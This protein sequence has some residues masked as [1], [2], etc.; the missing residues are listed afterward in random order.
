[1]KCVRVICIVLEGFGETGS[2]IGIPKM[3]IP[4]MDLYILRDSNVGSDAWFDGGRRKWCSEL[5]S[6]SL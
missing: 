4:E 2:G 1:M 6:R 5:K 3:D